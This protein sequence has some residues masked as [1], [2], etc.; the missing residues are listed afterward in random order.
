MKPLI[1][2]LGNDLISDD[3]IGIIAAR[4]LHKKLSGRADV[5]ESSLHGLALLDLFI[6]YDR[7]VIIDAIITGRVP[8]GTVMEMK[9]EDLR[10]SPA[11]S[12]HYTGL[13]EMVLL[14]EQMQIDFPRD[15][16]I[17]AVEISDNLT[18]GKGP[19]PVVANAI[20]ALTKHAIAFVQRWE[21]EDK[22]R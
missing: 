4:R 9:P 16:K 13:P 17:L 12:P 3:A 11:P 6:G 22:N 20:T 5:V 10:S 18:F 21:D 8:P 7:A 19:T 15:I 1:L 14:A 2:G